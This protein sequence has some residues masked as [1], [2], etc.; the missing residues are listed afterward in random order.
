MSYAVKGSEETAIKLMEYASRLGIKNIHFCTAKLKDAHQLAKRIKKR[1]KNIKK[2][3][4]KMT[5]EGMLIR[6]AIY[7]KPF[8]K[9]GKATSS[10]IEKVEKIKDLLLEI[11]AKKK[12]VYVDKDFA[13]VLTSPKIARKHI[14][15]LKENKYYS[16]IVEEYPT[17]D[18]FPIELEEL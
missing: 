8:K 16:Y 18:A 14:K 15:T 7:F 17:K 2:P 9:H 5:K 11:G 10:D 4:D 13:R 3:F 6:A 12:M 1:A